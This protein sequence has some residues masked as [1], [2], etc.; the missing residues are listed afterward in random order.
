M[1]HF[2]H[3]NKYDLCRGGNAHIVVGFNANNTPFMW[4]TNINYKIVSV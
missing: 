2:R 1:D 3:A 4:A